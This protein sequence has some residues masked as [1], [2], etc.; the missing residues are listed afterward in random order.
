MTKLL[1]LTKMAGVMHE[2]KITLTLS[3]APGDCIDSLPMYH[4]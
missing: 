4:S 2:A 1:K 3:G